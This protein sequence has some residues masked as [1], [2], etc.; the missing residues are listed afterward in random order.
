[1]RTGSVLFLTPA[2]G[3]W[4]L[5]DLDIE[6]SKCMLHESGNTHVMNNE[7]A[8]VSESSD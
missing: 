6:P 2:P 4:T 3:P 1:M 5:P 8:A 7:V